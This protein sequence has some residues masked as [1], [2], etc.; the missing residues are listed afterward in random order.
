MTITK[1]FNKFW[2]KLQ[3]L[4]GKL[5]YNKDIIFTKLK[6][7]LTSVLPKTMAASLNTTD[8]YEYVEQCSQ[9][10]QNINYINPINS[11]FKHNSSTKMNSNTRNQITL[12][13]LSNQLIISSYS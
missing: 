3:V 12:S 10:L 9:N 6:Y 8:F 13:Q 2:T 11:S 1:T 4:A 7:K 5:N